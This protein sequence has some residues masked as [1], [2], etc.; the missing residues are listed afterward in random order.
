MKTEDKKKFS[1]ELFK[2]LNEVGKTTNPISQ[3]S[4]FFTRIPELIE[5]VYEQGVKDGK[6]IGFKEG[7]QFGRKHYNLRL[8][9]DN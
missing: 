1:A 3:L 2:L 8:L 9:R 6:E 5:K 7:F 4:M